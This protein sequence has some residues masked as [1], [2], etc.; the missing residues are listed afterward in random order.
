[1]S[2]QRN[3][4]GSSKRESRVPSSTNQTTQKYKRPTCPST[5]VFLSSVAVIKYWP[6]PTWDG[7]ALFYHNSQSSHWRKTRQELKQQ[8]GGMNWSKSTELLT[9]L[10][11]RLILVPLRSVF[12]GGRTIHSGLGPVMPI[13]NEE[14][15]RAG[16]MAQ[17]LRAF[18]VFLRTQFAFSAEPK[19]SGTSVL[20][21]LILSQGLSGYQAHGGHVH[22]G[23]TLAHI[24]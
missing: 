4:K 20:R 16:K 19:P 17:H 8:P 22:V 15:A 10:L 13:I 9:G 24:K 14:N 3:S 7:K 11:T 21:F 6:K 5:E 2:P 18:I 1:M 23:K 12:P